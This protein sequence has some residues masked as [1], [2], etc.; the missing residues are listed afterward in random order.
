MALFKIELRQSGRN[1][2]KIY[3]QLKITISVSTR[4][5]N[6]KYTNLFQDHITIY[7]LNSLDI[8]KDVDCF[9]AVPAE[10]DSIT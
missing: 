6:Q 1:T 9:E 2:Y 5:F 10:P 4:N 3:L 7:C 8:T